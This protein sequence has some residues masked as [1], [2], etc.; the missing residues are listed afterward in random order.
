MLFSA[1][2]LKDRR[3]EGAGFGPALEEGGIEAGRPAE[4]D[5]QKRGGGQ[6]RQGRRRDRLLS[7]DRAGQGE[8]QEAGETEVHGKVGVGNAGVV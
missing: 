5:V 2:C 8:R 3:G 7:R 1:M 6:D 4:A